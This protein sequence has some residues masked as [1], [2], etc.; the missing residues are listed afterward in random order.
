MTHAI[1]SCVQI[2]FNMKHFTN[3]TFFRNTD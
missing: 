3:Q 2:Y 1:N